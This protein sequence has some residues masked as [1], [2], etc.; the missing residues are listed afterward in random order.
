MGT[1]VFCIFTWDNKSAQFKYAPEIPGPNPIPHPENKTITTHKDWMGGIYTDSVHKWT[2]VKFILIESSGRTGNTGDRR[3]GFA[4]HC[5][6]MVRGKMV[7]TLW[8]P[9]VCSDS[10]GEDPPLVCPTDVP[11]K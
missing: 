11:K 7:T 8:R 2:G 10:E 9:V 3:C 5:E 4:D 1:E 6:K